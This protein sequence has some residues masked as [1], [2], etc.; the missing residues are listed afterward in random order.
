MNSE[1]T[2]KKLELLQQYSNPTIV[3][4]KLR[5][6]YGKDHELYL[7]TRK[8]K[9]YM[10]YHPETNKKIHFGFFNPPMEDYTKHKD[11]KRREAFLKRNA[12]WATK[13]PYSPAR[14]SYFLT[15]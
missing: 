1:D 6:L 5:R 14:L 13:D 15:W 2:F 8:D 7:S 9:K 11:K 3:R 10:I 12:K 4:R